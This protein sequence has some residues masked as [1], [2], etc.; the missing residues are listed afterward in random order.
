MSVAKIINLPCVTKLDMP[1][2]R[3]LDGAE[4]G[5]LKQA[6]VIGWGEDDDFYFASSM[7]DGPEVLWLLQIAQRKLLAMGHPEDE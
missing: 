1:V 3:I 6:V 2:D 4:K 7:A 5:K